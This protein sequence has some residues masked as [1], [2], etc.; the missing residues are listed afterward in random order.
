M[1]AA[2]EIAQ[3]D[4][5][6]PPG[7]WPTVLLITEDPA[8]E[9]LAS[10]LRARGLR[11]AR[12]ATVDATSTLLT[13]SQ[14]G[15]L[16][17]L[18]TALPPHY[19]FA[20]VYRLL[21]AAPPVPALLLLHPGDAHT[22]PLLGEAAT[23][24]DDYGRLPASPEELVLRVQSLALRAGLPWPTVPTAPV[25]LPTAA[26]AQ[27]RHGQVIVLLG[28][29]GGVGRSTI[30]VNLAVGLARLYGKHVALLD[31][32]LWHGDVAV[33][34]DLHADRSIA[35]L[36][37]KADHL[38]LDALRSV[39]IPHASG[40]EVLLAP[41]SPA[42]VETIP[43]ALP[44]QVARLC[45]ALFDFVVVDMPSSLEEYVLQL[46][47]VADHVVMVTTPEVAALCNTAELLKLAPNLGW[48]DRLLL[49][50]NRANS[51][52]ALDQLEK[53]LGLP[54]DVTIVSAGPLILDS[55]NRGQPLLGRDVAGTER[56]TRDLGRLV[57]RIAGED[58]PVWAGKPEHTWWP[59]WRPHP[60]L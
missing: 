29:K 27:F 20:A 47:E 14:S 40:V 53:T 9:S 21:H 6:V 58:I 16:A 32:N 23:S 15:V 37:E 7:V 33:L 3:H 24:L 60:P 11:V 44:A 30:A 26:T 39:L 51:G 59:P 4:G 25:S 35:S 46:L 57:A 19:S 28:P 34:L 54:V 12:P 55:A 42:H 45:Q 49:V 48:A 31:A 56:V 13:T 38:D 5:A 10:A 43:A 22:H 17:V 2:G 50:L 1:V 8:L 52:V 18:D 36:V 41:P